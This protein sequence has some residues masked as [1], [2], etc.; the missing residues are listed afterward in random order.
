MG[1]AQKIID[2]K[3]LQHLVPFNALSPMHF[4]EV[5]QKTVVEEV[6]AGRVIFKEGERDNQSIYLLEGDIN[7]TSGNEV[8]GSVSAGSEASRHPIAQQ[9]PRQVAARAKTNCTIARIDSSLLDI[10]L[11]WDQS[12]GYEVAEIDD[13]Q[14]DDWMTRILQSQA[15][16][17]LP[18]SNIQRL[19]MSVESY[20]VRAGDVIIEQGGEG[21]YFYIIKTGRCMV[22]RK[23]SVNAKPV[24]LAELADGDAFGED[25]LVSDAKRNAS[26]TMMTD[27]VLMRLSKKDFNELLKEPLLNTVDYSAA[28][29]LMG[30]G[31]ELLD[32]RLPGEYE[33]VHI[34]DS[35]NLPLSALRLEAQSL[36][37]GRKYIVCCETG[38]RSA[39]AAFVL[40][41]RGFEVSVLE[42]GFASVPPEAMVGNGANP[43]APEAEAKTEESVPTAP[44]VPLQ[45]KPAST[46]AETV[47]APD[48]SA[49]LEAARRAQE[50]A[51]HQLQEL[52]EELDRVR[53][54]AREQTLELEQSLAE[55]R[56]KSGA[57]GGEMQ[58]LKSELEKL[59]LDLQVRQEQSEALEKDFKAQRAEL[60]RVGKERAALKA[61]LERGADAQSDVASE[62]ARL[63]SRLATLEPLEAQARAQAEQ[64]KTLQAQ[65]DAAAA[66]AKQLGAVR[67]ELEQRLSEQDK[68]ASARYTAL[69]T[70]LQQAKADLEGQLK[71]AQAQL[72]ETQK[73]LGQT[74]TEQ[75]ARIKELTAELG[76]AAAATAAA[77]AAASDQQAAL[78]AEL[79]EARQARTAAEQT[80]AALH[81]ELDAA[82]AQ[83]HQAGDADAQLRQLQDALA[84]ARQ[85]AEAAVEAQSAVDRERG[86]LEA[87]LQSLNGDLDAARG[88]IESLEADAAGQAE[89]RDRLAAREAELQK[90]LDAIKR[91]QTGEQSAMTARVAELEDA[92]KA[93]QQR[94]A[95]ATAEQTELQQARDRLQTDLDK[96]NAE[97]QSL[98]QQQAASGDAHANALQAVQTELSDTQARL[99]AADAQLQALQQ[100]QSATGSDHA[101]ALQTL[102]SELA[103]TRTKLAEADAAREEIEARLAEMVDAKQAVDTALE[104]ERKAHAKSLDAARAEAEAAARKEFDKKIRELQSDLDGARAALARE[105]TERSNLEAATASDLSAAQSKA[106]AEIER[107]MN[108]VSDQRAE[109][110]EIRSARDTLQ[111]ELETARSEA[112]TRQQAFA[113]ADQ[114]RKT[115]SAELEQLRS[116]T[117]ADLQ[118]MQKQMQSL[119]E[120]LKAARKSSSGGKPE[121]ELAR[122]RLLLDEARE[123][124][125]SAR[126]DADSWRE[127]AMAN[128]AEAAQSEAAAESASEFDAMRV[129]MADIQC[130]VDDALR[131]RDAAQQEVAQ[132]RLQIQQQQYQGDGPAPAAL[133]FAQDAESEAP[134]RGGL[135]TSLAIGLLMGIGGA[136]GALWYTQ[137]QGGAVAPAT[138]AGSAAQPTAPVSKSGPISGPTSGP[139]SGPAPAQATSAPKPAAKA[140]KPVAAPSVRSFRDSL[141]DG[142]QGPEMI[143]LNAA[144]YSMGS[145]T[146]S[147]DF[148]ERPKHEV[149]LE[150]FAIGKYEVTF[151]EYDAFARATG[152]ALPDD[153]GWGRGQRPVINVTWDEAIEYTRWL[154]EQ[155]G[156]AYRLPSEAEWEYAAGGSERTL[157]WWGNSLGENRANCF[158]CG[159]EWDA[160][161]SAPV[162]SFSANPLG[163]YDTA[164]NVAEWVQDCYNNS[165][166]GAPVDGSA[167][168]SRGCARRVARGGGLRSPAN[169]IRPA[170][171][172]QQ[173][174]NQRADDLGFRVVRDY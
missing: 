71:S 167:W 159:S 78:N 133:T 6:R 109:L 100:A 5:A 136:G 51:E 30:K 44:V 164:G 118:A 32:V 29:A 139:T 66:E 19:L 40:S 157:Y 106:G 170:K 163:L 102:Q 28:T 120:E 115:L 155:T 121:E 174:S 95:T 55:A 12:S 15:F 16:L 57:T 41:Q 35:R 9:Q 130:R 77:Q 124:A 2:K 129:Q 137:Q 56:Q 13:D 93:E 17:K 125:A 76:A 59:R 50:Q 127:H 99:S 53:E 89:A 25:A 105:Q 94:S 31:A 113:E 122:L 154:S 152:R 117:T 97:L 91:A 128:E 73:A 45:T 107:L 14:D 43:A 132:L 26:V 52:R 96:A 63:K 88:R 131:L 64:L 8:V 134:R 20:P 148:D 23:P 48:V 153:K 42:Q 110:T 108:E 36:D 168:V 119:T 1:A 101:E 11:T 69:E 70:Q 141:S 85:E 90:E 67:S 160:K 142:S 34:V 75:Q 150:R 27:G 104:Q 18:P 58:R 84:A 162:G 83:L 49:E 172:D 65:H 80:A 103:D 47:P 82:Q 173:P 38:R 81:N 151:D 22:T 10:M 145:G 140:D 39:S 111:A 112:Q 21:D 161:L 68:E 3:T 114:Q 37:R 144:T 86:E 169:T 143:E 87:Q 4:N 92:L 171:R 33:N 138:V 156:K 116:A 46:P 126:S 149:S 74:E 123:E 54:S 146:S 135:W 24:K 61:E 62:L 72:A 147:L 166:D 165:Y 98:Q 7:L 79:A 158:N 60:E